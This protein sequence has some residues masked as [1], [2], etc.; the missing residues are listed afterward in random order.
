MAY[1]SA[2]VQ[3]VSLNE[4]RFSLVVS[5]LFSGKDVA[6]VTLT[7]ALPWNY[8]D[9]QLAEWS[10]SRLEKLNSFVD[11][12]AGLK[13]KAGD[14]LPIARIVVPASNEPAE[15]GPGGALR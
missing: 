10:V 15:P 8:T 9:A 6:D 3:S 7:G 5:A 2:I 13:L 4:S 12:K 14:Q 1:E 11:T